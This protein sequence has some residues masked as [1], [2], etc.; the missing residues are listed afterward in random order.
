MLR[1]APLPEWTDDE[2]QL[3]TRLE[4]LRKARRIG[5][6]L[7]E[8]GRYYLSDSESNMWGT[9]RRCS[10]EQLWE[11]VHATEAKM[12][13][14]RKPVASEDSGNTKAKGAVA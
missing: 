4:T 2:H 12:A 1:P 6:V 5:V 14:E 8:C 11:L 10:K 9:K 3:L 13:A 7:A